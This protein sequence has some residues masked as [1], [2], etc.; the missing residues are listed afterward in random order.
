MVGVFKSLFVRGP[1]SV[2][3]RPSV[4]FYL[5]TAIPRK[6]LVGSSPNFVKRLSLW[7][8]YAPGYFYL[9][10][11]FNIAARR[12]SFKILLPLFLE[13]Y[14]LDL[15]QIL[16][17]GSPYGA[18]VHLGIFFFFFFYLI[19]IFNMAARRPSLKI[20]LPLFQENYRLDHL[21][22]LSSYAPGQFFFILFAYS[23]CGHL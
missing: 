9:I 7:C 8:S 11:V 22:I 3:H 1:W 4:N 21:Q 14:S 23:V 18:V 6:L 19:C 16:C 10:C 2:V 12:P 20:L 13:N 15:H 5:V 17:R